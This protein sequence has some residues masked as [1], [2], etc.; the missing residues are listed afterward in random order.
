[1]SSI[2]SQ[3]GWDSFWNKGNNIRQ[4]SEYVNKVTTVQRKT[5]DLVVLLMGGLGNTKWDFD[6][7]RDTIDELS[8]QYYDDEEV[9]RFLLKVR[10][11]IDQLKFT[12]E[13]M[14]YNSAEL[15]RQ[16]EVLTEIAAK[17]NRG[18]TPIFAIGA[19]SVIN[20]VMVIGFLDLR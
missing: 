2:Q 17:S 3:G 20:L 15:Q 4:I 10:G 19:L 16:G 12:E 14:E 1:M 11:T 6:I 8:Q 18:R 5:L 13:R 7:V 9:L